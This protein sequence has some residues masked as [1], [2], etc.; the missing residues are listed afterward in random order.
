MNLKY[1]YNRVIF[2]GRV[3]AHLDGDEK[4]CTHFLTNVEKVEEMADAILDT[5]VRSNPN[6]PAP[7]GDFVDKIES[8]LQSYCD[9]Y[10]DLNLDPTHPHFRDF[11][12]NFVDEVLNVYFDLKDR[13]LI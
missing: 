10:P 2:I 9:A 1:K 13:R 12:V 8:F 5:L 3:C 11:Y 7:T 6:D 4:L